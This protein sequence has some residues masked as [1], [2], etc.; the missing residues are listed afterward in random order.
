MPNTIQPR[1][2]VPK[3]DEAVAFYR[4]V[5]DA[6]EIFRYT[7]PS[8]A[9]AHCAL[10]IGDDLISLAEANDEYRLYS[11]ESLGGSPLLLTVIVEDAKA[12][13][14]AMADAG[15]TVVVPIEDRGYGKC[16]GRVQDPFG[17]LWVLSQD[18]AGASDTT[19]LPR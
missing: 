13:G 8:G 16:E 7:E 14:R 11:P 12:L 6:E 5:L 3:V 1:L 17:H 18:L 2:I 15:A 19:S 4:K 10:R 9:V